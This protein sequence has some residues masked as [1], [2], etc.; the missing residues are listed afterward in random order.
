M[1]LACITGRMDLWIWIR[2]HRQILQ[3]AAN[4]DFSLQV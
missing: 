4:E 1:R 2:L 3:A